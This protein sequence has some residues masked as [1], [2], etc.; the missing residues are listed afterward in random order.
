MRLQREN[1][2]ALTVRT[3][4]LYYCYYSLCVR[5]QIHEKSLWLLK[6]TNIWSATTV[7]R[8]MLHATLQKK[9][10]LN[11]LQTFGFYIF[12]LCMASFFLASFMY[13]RCKEMM[14][15]REAGMQFNRSGIYQNTGTQA[16]GQQKK[17]HDKGKN[18][19]LLSRPWRK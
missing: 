15:E 9:G 3:V 2:A 5:T 12:S 4:V 13:P 8:N 18:L 1:N 14:Q 11:S 7:I 17:Y 16:K 6:P 19:E 10:H